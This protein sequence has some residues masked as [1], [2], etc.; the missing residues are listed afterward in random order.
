MMI[1]VVRNRPYVGALFYGYL[2]SEKE[3]RMI[4]SLFFFNILHIVFLI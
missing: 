3:N 2:D 4:N 1:V